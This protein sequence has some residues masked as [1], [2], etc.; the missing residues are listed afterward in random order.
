MT[1]SFPIGGGGGSEESS[2]LSV[3]SE[4][5][6][7]DLT[8]N[9]GDSTYQILDPNNAA[10]DITLPA[11][12]T[13]PTR[14]QITN[15]QLGGT[16]TQ[17]FVLNV[18]V[19]SDTSPF[20]VI[21][22]GSTYDF[23]YTDSGWE[24]YGLGTSCKRTAANTFEDRNMVAIGYGV[25]IRKSTGLS[26]G[27]TSICIGYESTAYAGIAIGPTSSAFPDS[28][29]MGSVADAGAN[30][31]LS[32]GSGSE[33][34]STY[35][36]A[37]GKNSYTGRGVTLGY[38]SSSGTL[39]QTVIGD[40]LTASTRR[41]VFAKGILTS[42]SD[43]INE[44]WGWTDTTTDGT[45]KELTFANAGGLKAVLAA[46][47]AIAFRI[48]VVAT[49]NATSDTK[50]W[51]ILG[52]IKRDGSNNTSLVGSITKTVVAADTGASSW[53][54]TVEA[55]DSNEA[56]IIKGTGEA[57]HTIKWGAKAEILDRR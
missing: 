52:A 38:N 28:I 12:P 2:G 1:I 24:F 3:N 4:V 41:G 21:G 48:K 36:I 11:E 16:S 13:I 7:A 42:G 31:S 57:S 49:E 5:L 17:T 9:D 37:I 15:A 44:E 14:F 55:D 25:K 39:F 56:L 20:C 18:Y 27:D 29:A 26:A 35:G 34:D 22:T 46:N 30:S 8:I 33:V 53:D 40:G 43:I 10:R 45:Q 54:V 23:F 50:F 32:L 19:G 51:E 47:S 6:S